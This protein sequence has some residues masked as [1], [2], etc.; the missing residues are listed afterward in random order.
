MEVRKQLADIRGKLVLDL[1]CGPGIFSNVCRELGASVVAMD[2]SD[3]MLSIARRRY[4]SGFP[5][6]QGVAKS[7][8]FRD[9]IFDMVLALD[10]I[11]HLYEP[12][13]V[14]REVQRVMKP[15]GIIVLTTPKVGASIEYL[16]APK[17]IAMKVF[18][19]LPATI[20]KSIRLKVIPNLPGVIKSFLMRTAASR[21][22]SCTHVKVYNVRELVELVR[23]N[24]FCL[25]YM[26]TFPNR[27]S[28]GV[29]GHVVE[30]LFVG[31]LRKYKWRSAIYRF[32]REGA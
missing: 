10:V 8:P 4:E 20:Q 9:T 30:S 5:T 7:L 1:G 11:E 3:S 19:N 15:C 2:F 18:A 12:E 16:L 32:R 31:P 21:K 26:D 22:F 6:I 14:L 27:G 29:M 25:E 13:T 17:A 28:F 24:G 23:R